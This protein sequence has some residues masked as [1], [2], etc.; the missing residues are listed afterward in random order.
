[1]KIRKKRKVQAGDSFGRLVVI[2]PGYLK[3]YKTIWICRCSCG[4]L[5]LVRDDNLLSAKAKSCGCLQIESFSKVIRA[6]Q[7]RQE[8]NE[9][10][11]RRILAS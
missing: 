10:K 5:T 11:A 6:T 3:E 1:M 7:E 8:I 2:E 9:A 4:R